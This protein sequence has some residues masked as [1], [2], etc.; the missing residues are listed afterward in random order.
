MNGRKKSI[1]Q[2]LAQWKNKVNYEQHNRKL[3]MNDLWLGPSPSWIPEYLC[4][5]L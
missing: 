3:I 5:G 2:S 4:M 1:S